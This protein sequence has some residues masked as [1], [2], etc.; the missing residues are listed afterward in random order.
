MNFSISTLCFSTLLA[1]ALSSCTNDIQSLMDADRAVTF[2]TDAA[3]RATG[4]AWEAGDAIGVFMAASGE[5]AGADAAVRYETPSGDGNFSSASPLYF[6]SDGSA[7]DFVAYYPYDASLNGTTYKVNVSDQSEPAKID[8][9]RADNLR[10][11]SL[12]NRTARLDF[13]HELATLTLRL[14]ATDGTALDGLTATLEDVAT[15]ADFDLTTGAFSAPTATADVA[16]RVTAESATSATATALLIPG[17][18]AEGLK[19]TLRL[20]GKAQTVAPALTQLA[21][22]SDYTFN[23]NVTGGSGT[24]TGEATYF[25]RTET[26]LITNA[27]LEQDN[28]HYIVHMMASDPSVRNYAMLYDSDLKIAYWVAYPLCGYYTSGDGSRTDD[29]QFDPAL[30]TQLQANLRRGFD[31]YDRGHQIPSADRVT[32][33]VDNA[34]TFYYTNMTPQL[35]KG[36]NQ[37]IWANL[38]NRVR[39]WS[40]GTDTLFVVTG[41]MPTTQTDQTVTYVKDNDGKNVAVP[42]YYFKALARKIGGQFYTIAFK[43]DQK[44]YSNANG[45]MDCAMSVSDLEELTGFTFFPT[46][47][48]SAKETLDLTKWQ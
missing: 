11:L 44:T 32:T 33:N 12:T 42:K 3:H 31:G 2:T 9:M 20:G 7:V 46:I 29:W 48:T 45:Y 36:L 1:A 16:M 43:L 13:D 10:G 6:P 39:G 27:Q 5:T 35:G 34:T 41:A 8:L 47:S 22:G 14:T 38:E 4:T 18:Y 26:P 28:L 17:T 37:S 25:K 19:V 15:Q 40:S 23:L 30:S 24:A 21:G